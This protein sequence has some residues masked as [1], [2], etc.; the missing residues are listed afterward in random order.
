MQTNSVLVWA[1]IPRRLESDNKFKWS[2]W[3]VYESYKKSWYRAL[4]LM[5]GAPKPNQ[6]VSVLQTAMPTPKRGVLILSLRRRQLDQ[7]NLV[8]GAKPIPDWL[9]KALWLVDDDPDNVEVCY[10]QRKVSR[11]EDEL[12][13]VA[14]ATAPMTEE[15]WI[16]WAEAV[17]AFPPSTASARTRRRSGARSQ[18]SG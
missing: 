17:G 12:T 5:F 13:V 11:L 14:V 15:A 2:P 18:S 16:A 1:K 10:A 8:G 4:G 3:Y 9:V 6:S 7:G